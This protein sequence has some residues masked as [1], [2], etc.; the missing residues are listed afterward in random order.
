MK[1]S[2]LATA[3][4][5]AMSLSSSV[6]SA[7]LVN[8]DG[9]TFNVY[10]NLQFAY[11]SVQA[12]DGGGD[13]DS[14]NE[15][16]DNGSTIGFS[17]EH[18]LNDDLTA[19]FKYEFE[20]DADEIKTGNGIDTGNQAYFGLRARETITYPFQSPLHPALLRCSSIK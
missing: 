15:F 17:G 7:D 5:D 1:K 2:L 12:P 18:T 9:T 11:G 13:I 14:S 10:G 4:A 19:Y 16:G 20:G 6:Y 3:V 8:K